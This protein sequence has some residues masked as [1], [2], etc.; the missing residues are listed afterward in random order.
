MERI[1]TETEMQQFFEAEKILRTRG[2]VVDDEDGKALVA[3]NSGR[4]QAFFNLNTHVVATVDTI[5]DACER[6]KD[7]LHWKSAAQ[8]A[9]DT[10]YN[11]LSQAQKDAFGSWW[12][13]HKNV[14]I[15]DGDR[16]YENA[17]KILGW[18][19]G[20]S[21]DPR[22]FDL[23]VGN[24]A[25]TVGLHLA[26]QSTFR[27]GRHSGGDR[28]FMSK[29]DTNLSARDHAAR[30]AADSASASGSKPV[31]TDYRAAA[32]SV[33]GRTHSETERLNK[34]FVMKPGTSDIDWEK[35]N[36]ARRRVAGL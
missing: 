16:G 15:L 12:Y 1:F 5:L 33:R 11:A 9:Y 10:V 30:R 26:H 6:M 34:V 7:Q 25:G 14:L 17:A 4:I 13:A 2:L 27:P 3:H 22:T 19:K 21:F 29:S 20:R 23:A 28:S 32:E 24:L 31:E 36:A 35:T 8:M 18:M